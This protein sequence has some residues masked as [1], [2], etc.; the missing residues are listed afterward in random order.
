[1]NRQQ[2]RQT[3]VA[4]ALALSSLSVGNAF[5]ARGAPSLGATNDSIENFTFGVC[6]GTDPSCYHNWGVNHNN[7]VLVYSRTAAE[8]SDALGNALPSG[9]ANSTPVSASNRPYRFHKSWISTITCEQPPA[10]WTDD[11]RV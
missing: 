11:R 4:A 1:M 6:M 10:P 3:I 8:R 5:A 7:T 2:Y 9:T